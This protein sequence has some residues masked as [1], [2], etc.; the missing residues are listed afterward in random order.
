MV[1]GTLGS[2]KV[3]MLCAMVDPAMGSQLRGKGSL[4]KADLLREEICYRE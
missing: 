4:Q 2:G 1:D 3:L